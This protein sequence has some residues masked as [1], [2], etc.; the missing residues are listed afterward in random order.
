MNS[1]TIKQFIKL[2]FRTF[3][4][5]IILALLNPVLAANVRG[6]KLENYRVDV[7]VN[8]ATVV[9][10]L[11][12]IEEQTDFKFVYD[13]KVE[14]L[15]KTYDIAYN[16]VSLRSILELMAKDADLTF[17]RINNTISID[18]KPKAPKRVVEIAFITVTGTVT[19]E[20][21]VPLAGA[22]VQEKGTGNGSIT[23]FDG[24]YTIDV[25]SNAVLQF[26]YL[27]YTPKEVA[28]DGR[29]TIDVQLLQDATQL[30]DVVVVGYGTQRKTDVTGSIASVES[31]DFNKGIVM[32]P[33]QLLQGKVAGVNISNVSGEPGA[34]QDVII[35]G[36]G[37]LRSGTTP[38]YV[39]DGFALDNTSTGVPTNPLNFINPQDI[40]SIDVLKDA[41]A[42]AIYGARAANGVIVI[43]TKKGKS[44]RTQMDLSVSTGFSSLANKVD[45]FSAN[46]FRQQVVAAGGNLDDGGANTD[47]QDALSRTGFS[48]NVN[49]SMGGGADKFTYHASLGV[50]DQEGILRANDLKRYS[51]RLNLTQKA[52]NDRFKVEFNMTASRTEN[53]RA[54]ARSIVGDMLQLNPTLPLYTDG[55]PTLLDNALNPLTREK[56]FSDEAVNHRILANVAPSIE[57]IDGLTY[58]L[59]LGVDYSTTDRDVQYIPYSLLEGYANGSLTS[60]YTTNKNTLVENT[61][62]YNFEKDK[63]NFTVL[64]GHTYQ[65]TFVHQKSFELE[66]FADN[67]IE[68]K[69]Q[70]QIS[71]ESTQTYM[72]TY[73][74]ENEL[75]SFFGRVNYAF[76]NKYLL[77]A[78]MRADGSSKFGGNNKYGYFP[79]VALGWNIMNEDF[80]ST[81]ATIN[82]LK[83]RASWGKTGNQEIPSKITKLSYTDS[84]DG[85]DSYP[86]N[87]DESSLEDY[88]YGTIFTRLANPDIQ[89]EVSQQTDIGLDFGL[90]NNRLSGTLDYFQKV[91]KNIL[92]EV[93][94][95]D[96]IQPTDKFWTNI[97]DMEIKNNGI[98]FAL[99]YHSDYSKDFSYN[100]G[101][102]LAYT[103]NEVANS[104]YKVLT[105]GAA[106]GAGQTDA[107]INGN[108]NGEPI[109]SFY[110][111]EF[112]GIGDDGLSI[113]SEDRKVVGSALPDLVYAFYLNFKYKDFDLGLNFNGV[114]GN[115]VYNHTAMS[116]FKK[117]L[118]ASNFNTTSIA[119]EYPNE[120]ITNS[121]AV[122]TRYLEKGD[123]LRLNNA[124]L[125]YSL[126]PALIGLDGLVNTIRLSVTGQNLF[127]ITDYT[128]FDPE[129]NSNLTIDGIQTFGIDYFNYPKARTVVFGLNVS[130]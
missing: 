74:T 97:P 27:G 4:F 52:L 17:R 104:P 28:V 82:N 100:I 33:G 122:S 73:A 130:F 119:S 43:T 92:L 113:L 10:V 64:A 56:I 5:M 15:H 66:G 108:I 129:I 77:T 109:G 125:G 111:Q 96:P 107:T 106:Q 1:L 26:S 50:N 31:E 115:K 123:F 98:E 60:T 9:E 63:H 41:S 85:N 90:F 42:A 12:Q 29:T 38:L 45:V 55:Q 80:M 6:Q 37:S 51:G 61:L 121:N 89:W 22:S 127:V 69:Y 21:G 83:L 13:R 78:T 88:P 18:V 57:I 68:P 59:N 7:S 53:L 91:S 105:T 117:G 2:T 93:T 75:Q 128:G 118:L 72:Y 99:D 87:G 84:K 25:E 30:E 44:G 114:S 110:M 86:I 81:N 16:K 112:L 11:K 14:R 70:D 32:N 3:C 71:G 39:I 65:K 23:D 116:L 35:R 67:G 79:S 40:E 126:R 120:D 19:D 47:W 94:P 24:N 101:G 58:K 103:K 95:A 76:D 102:N 8:D 34:A 20:N 36:V 48:K 62:T 49:L 124:T 46:E 54:D